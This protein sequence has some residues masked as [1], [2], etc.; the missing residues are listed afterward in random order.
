VTSPHE[1]GIGEYVDTEQL[2]IEKKLTGVSALNLPDR[3]WDD[4]YQRLVQ[5]LLESNK[6][7]NLLGPSVGRWKNTFSDQ[8]IQAH[9]LAKELK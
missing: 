4:S 3:N 8:V 2:Q 7:I 1:L 9:K 5:K 6:K